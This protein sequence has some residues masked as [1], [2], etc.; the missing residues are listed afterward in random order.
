MPHLLQVGDWQ[1]YFQED[2]E[3]TKVFDDWVKTNANGVSFPFKM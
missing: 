2:S 3:F 1:N